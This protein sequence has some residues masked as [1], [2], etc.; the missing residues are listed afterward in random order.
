[1]KFSWAF[2]L[3]LFVVAGRAQAQDA[4]F[5]HDYELLMSDTALTLAGEKFLD[6]DKDA[7]R[8]WFMAPVF[9]LTA[10]T[11]YRIP[12]WERP[13]GGHYAHEFLTLDLPGIALGVVVEILFPPAK[14]AKK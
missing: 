5:S 3:L 10:D 4:G 13:D 6:S 9:V 2:L 11:L 8:F 1:M 14:E 7:R 12:E